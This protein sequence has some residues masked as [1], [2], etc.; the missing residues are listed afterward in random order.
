MD[1]PTSMTAVE[2]DIETTGLVFTVTVTLFVDTV[3][4]DAGVAPEETPVSVKTK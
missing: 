2:G 1:W 4:E 3:A